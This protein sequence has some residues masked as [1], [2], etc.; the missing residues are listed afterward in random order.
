MTHRYYSGTFVVANEP[1][2]DTVTIDFDKT[3]LPYNNLDSIEVHCY[4]VLDDEGNRISVIFSKSEHSAD[5]STVGGKEFNEG[6]A[7]V[8]DY[9]IEKNNWQLY[10]YYRSMFLQIAYGYATTVHR[11]QGSSVDRIYLN[12]ADVLHGG[13]VA[14]A[15]AYVAATRA[16][17]KLHYIIT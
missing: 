15:L 16:R 17:K 6:L 12:P 9:C 7:I 5:P 14:P 13:T 3:F 11:S 2:T 4:R 8:K 10:H 1:V